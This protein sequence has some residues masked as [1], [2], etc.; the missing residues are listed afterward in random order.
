MTCK[1]V[2]H[3]LIHCVAGLV[4]LARR[5]PPHQER[6]GSLWPPLLSEL[7]V[8]SLIAQAP[9]KHPVYGVKGSGHW[10]A[11]GTGLPNGRVLILIRHE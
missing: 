1:A 3:S 11:A 4:V 7:F 6:T 8:H 5:V 10:E 2:A 9:T